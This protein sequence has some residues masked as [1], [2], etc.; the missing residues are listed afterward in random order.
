MSQQTKKKKTGESRAGE[1]VTLPLTRATASTSE[2]AS[3][4]CAV[5]WC[6]CLASHGRFCAAHRLRES[7]RPDYR[8]ADGSM[9]PWS[10]M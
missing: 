1:P 10:E 9:K 5:P 3:A 4:L 2:K 8:N 7:L 6:A